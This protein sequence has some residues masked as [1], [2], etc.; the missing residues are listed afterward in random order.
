M[1]PRYDD[2]DA[3]ADAIGKQRL[4]VVGTYKPGTFPTRVFYVRK[5]VDPD[6]REFGKKACQTTTVNAFTALRRGYR[7]PFTMAEKGG[8]R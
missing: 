8:A 4:T 1:E 3:V 6:G 2:A 7:H 5:W